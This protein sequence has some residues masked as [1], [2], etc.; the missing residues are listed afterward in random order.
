MH[1]NNGRR[2][3]I[4]LTWLDRRKGKF[5][6]FLWGGR[7]VADDDDD[8]V[9]PNPQVTLLLITVLVIAAHDKGE[10]QKLSAHV[11]MEII[12]T[13][14]LYARDKMPRLFL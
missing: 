12:C 13:Y 3:R 5:W 10:S 6:T 9:S 8:G 1:V 11:L 2:G 14:T 4:H 7:G